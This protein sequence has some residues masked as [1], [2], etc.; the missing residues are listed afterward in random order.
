M[1]DAIKRSFDCV[2][3]RYKFGEEVYRAL[4]TDFGEKNWEDVLIKVLQSWYPHSHVEKVSGTQE[5]IHGTD[6][7]VRLPGVSPEQEFAIAIQVKDFENQV[8]SYDVEEIVEQINKA[9]YWDQQPSL[10]LTQV[11]GFKFGESAA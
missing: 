9:S 8:N 6:I 11:S 10:K 5:K 1:T 4:N 3:D 2:F 7:L